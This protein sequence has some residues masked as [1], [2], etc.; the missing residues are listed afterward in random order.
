M[1]QSVNDLSSSPE[2]NARN[3][4]KLTTKLA[5]GGLLCLGWFGPQY[6]QNHQDYQRG[7][8]A[9]RQAECQEAIANFQKVIQRELPIFMKSH[10]QT[11]NARTRECQDYLE[12][13]NPEEKGDFPAALLAY[14]DFINQYRRTDLVDSIQQKA[15]KLLDEKTPDVLV[16]P[17]LCQQLDEFLKTKLIRNSAE[18]FPPLY[19]A[20]GE[21]YVQAGDHASA[22]EIYEQFLQLYLQHHLSSAVEIALIQTLIADAEAK[23]ATEIPQP[24]A[25]G[26]TLFGY[27][28]VEIQNDSPTTLEFTFAGAK[29]GFSEM[30]PCFNCQTEKRNIAFCPECEIYQT[31]A[32]T[33]EG[34]PNKARATIPA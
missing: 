26:Q 5:I 15:R 6:W 14:N 3:W 28:E 10:T 1:P 13:V 11:A 33:P 25:V 20:C 9:Y 34:C 27:T 23:G 32:E 2:V 7:E 8:Q 21:A 29:P 22:I 12:A 17:V 30:T 18:Q 31:E 4:G 19:H 16:N 24:L